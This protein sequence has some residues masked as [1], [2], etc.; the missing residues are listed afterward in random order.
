LNEG[1]IVQIMGCIVY[2]VFFK[3]VSNHKGAKIGWSHLKQAIFDKEFSNS[4][5][6]DMGNINQYDSDEP[7]GPGG[8]LFIM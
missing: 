7:C 1:N 5:C 8:L 6:V 4:M 3:G 2:N